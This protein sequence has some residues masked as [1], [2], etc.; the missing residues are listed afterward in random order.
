MNKT[1][2]WVFTLLFL[3]IGWWMNIVVLFGMGREVQSIE[4]FARVIGFVIPPL[5]GIMGYM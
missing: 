5:G 4:G 1:F 2:F 3:V